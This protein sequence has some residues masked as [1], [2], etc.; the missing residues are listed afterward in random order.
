M[1]G[2]RTPTSQ[3]NV[4]TGPNITIIIDKLLAVVDDAATKEKLAA[5]LLDLDGMS[6]SARTAPP[7]IDAVARPAPPAIDAGAP[8]APDS[9]T[10][11]GGEPPASGD[12]VL[13]RIMREAAA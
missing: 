8:P 12:S 13:D 11:D 5:A 4:N 1:T 9:V 7:T 3:V 2:P 6:A 10:C